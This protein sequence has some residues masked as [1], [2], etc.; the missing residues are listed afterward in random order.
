MTFIKCVIFA[1]RMLLSFIQ[2]V[3]LEYSG[4]LLRAEIELYELLHELILDAAV[5]LDHA[6]APFVTVKKDTV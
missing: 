5:Y 6:V 3:Q 4:R 2:R 1:T